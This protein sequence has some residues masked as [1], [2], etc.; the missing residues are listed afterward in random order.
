MCFCA[1][2]GGK[3]A[4]LF[5]SEVTFYCLSSLEKR[6]RSNACKKAEVQNFWCK[7]HKVIDTKAEVIPLT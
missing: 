1:E 5:W 7:H 6:V 2:F 4:N 3:T